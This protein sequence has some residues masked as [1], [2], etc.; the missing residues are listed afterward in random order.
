MSNHETTFTPHPIPD[1]LIEANGGQY[2]LDGTGNLRAIE[3]IKPADKLR[4]EMIRREF[5]FVL[6]LHHQVAR[7]K[8]HL[9]TNLGSF[10]AM[11]AQEYDVKI[12]GRKGNRSY[13]SVDGLWRIIVRM[14]DHIAY[15]PEM[16]AAKALFDEC[17]NEWAADTR[18]ALRSIVSK[19]FDTN[20]EGQINRA[21]IHNLLNTEDDDPRWKRGQQAIR[22]AMYMIGA[23]EYVRFE[24]RA[25]CR[26]RWQSVTIDLA[27]A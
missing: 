13:T 25:D 1:G 27:S 14:H 5:G 15:G 4:D 21:N 18:P 11:M 23:K 22:D 24:M 10:D 3:N 2:M 19:A 12:G 16:Q 26:D 7:F 9:M 6:A 8:G 20:K 17:L